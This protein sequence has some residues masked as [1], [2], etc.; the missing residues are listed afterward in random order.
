[1]NIALVDPVATVRGLCCSALLR[2]VL[3]IVREGEQ[4]T[5]LSKFIAILFQRV[6]LVRG[7]DPI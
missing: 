2:S 3:V 1:M 7:A 4:V 6:C 5:N